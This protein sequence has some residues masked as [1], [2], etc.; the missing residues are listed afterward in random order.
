MVVVVVYIFQGTLP[1]VLQLHKLLC[2][3]ICLL[4]HFSFVKPFHSL[5]AEVTAVTTLI[6]KIAVEAI[7]DVIIFDDTTL[8]SGV[9]VITKLL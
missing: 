4:C 9:W 5:V 7:V 2:K 3:I 6:V 8:N 1:L